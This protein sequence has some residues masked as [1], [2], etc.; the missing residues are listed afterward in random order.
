MI[1]MKEIKVATI[2]FA[3][4]LIFIN[5]S[6]ANDEFL[7]TGKIRPYWVK[8][9]GGSGNDIAKS[10]DAYGDAIYIVGEV[11]I[12]G[13]K[14]AF[15]AKYNERGKLEW[16]KTL[17]KDAT[18]S[19]LVVYDD[20]IYVVGTIG[21]NDK[22]IFISKVSD[23]GN[24]LWTKT[25]GGS[26]DDVAGGIAA[27]N[28]AIYI[29]GYTKGFGAL[30]KDVVLLKYNL[31]GNITWQKV[32]GKSG[33]EEGKD[34]AVSNNGIYIV[35]DTT[36]YGAGGKDV[37]LLK[38]DLN[39]DF[40]WTKTWGGGSDDAATSIDFSQGNIYVVGYTASYTPHVLIL[41]YDVEGNMLFE[42]RW[43]GSNDDVANGVRVGNAIY[44]VGETKSY[45]REGDIFLLKYSLEGNL[46]FAKTWGGKGEDAAYDID[47]NN[48]KIY[49]VG[50]TKSYG[51]G[52]K[53][54]F[55][56]KCNLNGRKS[57]AIEEVTIITNNKLYI[58]G[59]EIISIATSSP[60]STSLTL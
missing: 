37:L 46:Q 9:F 49:I 8:T 21:K 54:A 32:W 6:F 5:F 23:S 41:K 15:I 40:V 47:I 51:K 38:F 10:V 1:K 53:D 45:G 43:G 31:N 12:S 17:D 27:Y 19:D 39:G 7:S 48:D 25:W 28:D 30:Q 55:L 57:L 42:R 13:E 35:G 16:N 59:R 18:A 20:N 26:S 60:K 29:C 58:C 3:L 52:G 11:N 14:Y 33:N 4:L 50:Y 44:I 2:F 22:N 24:I 34:I 56:L 36:S